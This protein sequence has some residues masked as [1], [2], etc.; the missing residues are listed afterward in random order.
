MTATVSQIPAPV[1][2]MMLYANKCEKS[3][4][5][6]ERPWLQISPKCRRY[7]QDGEDDDGGK[8][9]RSTTEFERKRNPD[10]IDKRIHENRITL[11]R[12]RFLR[13]NSKF[14]NPRHDIPAQASKS[15]HFPRE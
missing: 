10:E 14:R 7:I 8:P 4:A 1:E 15:T 3:P 5:M 13:R 12:T 11:H 6:E 9:S 2:A